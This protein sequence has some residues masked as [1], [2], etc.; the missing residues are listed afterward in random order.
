MLMQYFDDKYSS[1]KESNNV[2]LYYCKS[3]PLSEFSISQG[4][5]L[6]L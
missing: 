6:N 3:Q 5:V 4:R 1:S 2:E